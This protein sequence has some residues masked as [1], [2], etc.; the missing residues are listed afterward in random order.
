MKWILVLMGLLIASISRELH[1]SWTLRTIFVRFWGKMEHGS[2]E[3]HSN[4]QVD[5]KFLQH[6]RA[7]GAKKKAWELFDLCGQN[8]FTQSSRFAFHYKISMGRAGK[9]PSCD[10]KTI[11]TEMCDVPRLPTKIFPDCFV[12]SFVDTSLIPAEAF[13]SA[14]N[15]RSTL[16]L[17]G[18]LVNHTRLFVDSSSVRAAPQFETWQA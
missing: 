12:I 3:G 13:C 15:L 14:T 9:P 8:F 6:A 17:V 18:W 7:W 5:W 10:S 11:R 16:W 2:A 1:K 4:F